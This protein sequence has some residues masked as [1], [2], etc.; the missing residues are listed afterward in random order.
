M[1]RIIVQRAREKGRA[2]NDTLRGRKTPLF[3]PCDTGFRSVFEVK[4]WTNRV[5]NALLTKAWENSGTS[6][7][8][9]RYIMEYSPPNS[10]SVYA[11]S[12]MNSGLKLFWPSGVFRILLQTFWKSLRHPNVNLDTSLSPRHSDIWQCVGS[13][14]PDF[15]RHA[16]N[17]QWPVFVPL[18]NP[19][20]GALEKGKFP[21]GSQEIGLSWEVPQTTRLVDFNSCEGNIPARPPPKVKSPSTDFS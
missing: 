16:V 4:P 11:S 14:T 18:S 12:A 19:S 7:Y 17:N 3:M 2:L 13:E 6:R 5:T 21:F 8:I 15:F 1:K 20:H 10:N 9:M